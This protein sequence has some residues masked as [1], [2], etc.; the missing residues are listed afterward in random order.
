MGDKCY[1]YFGGKLVRYVPTRDY[2]RKV[3][4]LRGFIRP[5]DEKFE[6]G[7]SYY[8]IFGDWYVRREGGWRE[9]C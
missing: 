7:S 2:D 6:Y 9:S 3:M 8:H 1:E 5:G 4:Q